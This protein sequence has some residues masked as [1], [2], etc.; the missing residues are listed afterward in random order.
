MSTKAVN[1]KWDEYEIDDMK[2]VASV[3]NITLTDL[4][5]IA[6]KEYLEK[7]KADPFYRLTANVEAASEDESAEILDEI[8][9]LGDE[10]LKI[11]SSK[12]FSI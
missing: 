3:F 2:K 4:V 1:F 10:D 12:K 7:L 6:C 11:V 9:A 5:K 8:N